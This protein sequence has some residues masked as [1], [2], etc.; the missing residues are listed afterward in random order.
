[1]RCRKDDELLAINAMKIM[2]WDHD[3]V[4][5]QLRCQGIGKISLVRIFVNSS[6]WPAIYYMAGHIVTM[7][8][9][10]SAA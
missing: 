6:L 8:Q 10:G 2:N 3:A 5:S 9:R 7:R 4:L 1:M